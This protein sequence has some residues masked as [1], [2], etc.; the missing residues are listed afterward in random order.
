MQL[1]N[2]DERMT[3]FLI[4]CGGW[5]YFQVPR[6]KPLDAYARAFNFVEVNST[7]YEIPEIRTVR[8]WRQRVPPDFEFAVRC[9]KDVTHKHQLGPTE[10]AFQIMDTMI[11]ICKALQSR[12]LVL[13]TPSEL[14]FSQEKIRSI[15]D[16]F[17]GVDMK[18]VRYAW[19]IRRTT[20]EPIPPQIVALMSDHNIIHSV[21]ISKE[22]PAIES[23]TV[24]SRVFGKGEHNVYQFTDDEL[25]EIDEKIVGSGSELTAVSFHNVRMYRD[26][27]RFKIYKET[28]MFSSVTGAEGQESLRKVL[29][30]DAEFPATKTKLL[31]DQGWKVIDLTR[32]RRVH[33]RMLLDELPDRQFG[34]IEEVMKSLPKV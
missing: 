22:T 25:Q 13:Q 15:G 32:N 18:G 29:K 26:A 3:D 11:E 1:F 20:G 6:L 2:I 21:D 5:A 10:E 7:F 24:Y 19:E 16:F 9:H 23:D 33:A 27:A 30:E 17:E 8:S 4:G 14:N 12:F 34:S 28:G 31:K